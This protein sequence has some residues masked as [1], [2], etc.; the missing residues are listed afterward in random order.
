MTP[1]EISCEAIYR[2][3]LNLIDAYNNLRDSIKG[4][5]ENAG[6]FINTANNDGKNDNIYSAIYDYCGCG[7][8]VEVMVKAV[9]LEGDLI[10]CYCVPVTNTK[11]IYTD[12]YMKNDEDNWYFL[13]ISSD[14]VYGHTLHF[15]ADVFENEEYV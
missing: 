14:L 15:L 2:K 7:E 11:T 12:E 13:D 6:G 9:K 1:I 5:I 10:Y 8:L 4:L 3:K